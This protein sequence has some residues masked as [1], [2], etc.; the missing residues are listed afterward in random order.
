MAG[1]LNTNVTTDSALSTEMKTYY[2][3]YMI[4]NAEAV[5]VHDQF[6]QKEPIPKNGGKTV[7][8]RR[9]TKFPKALTPLTEGIT[10]DGRKMTVTN[11]T[12]TVAQYGDYVTISDMLQMTA[13]D[14][15][16]VQATRLCG[17]Q[18]G[19]TMDTITREVLVGGT[20]VQ[21]ANGEVAARNLLKGQQAT[22]NHYMT[23]ATLR[24]AK[25]NLKAAGVPTLEDG[26]YVA[27]MHTDCVTDLMGDTQWQDAA[28]FGKP[29][30]LFK[31]EVGSIA[32]FRI[33]ETTEAKV[34]VNG[35]AKKADGTAGDG[36]TTCVDVYATM[37]LGTDGYA[38][39]EITG[40]GLEH[41]TKQLGSA[42]TGDPLNQRATVGWKA[43]KAVCR[44]NE[45]WVLR[46]ETASA[47]NFGA[48]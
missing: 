29:E 40:G 39:T 35:G 38:T 6:A 20:N 21:Y 28:K 41:I 24:R 14:N 23:T 11:V 48:N 47:F 16:I 7:E 34:F 46:V 31:G 30:Q 26:M 44:L 22:T 37:C 5:L 15:N 8:F 18:A 27:I 42:G 45:A 3:N 17:I 9:Y 19:E 13:L 12:A 33:I 2:S 1:I 43:T 4:K 36:T 25:R 10:P 32:G